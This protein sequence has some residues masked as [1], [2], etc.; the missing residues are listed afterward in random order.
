MILKTAYYR[1]SMLKLE[2]LKGANRQLSKRPT[3]T[4]VALLSSSRKLLFRGKLP[5][6]PLWASVLRR[7]KFGVRSRTVFYELATTAS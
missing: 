3:F 1:V 4:T 6:I 2:T 5:G 7:T